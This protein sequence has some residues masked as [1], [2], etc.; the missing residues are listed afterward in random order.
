VTGKRALVLDDEPAVR[1][2]VAT[3]LTGHGYEVDAVDTV[4]AGE[5]RLGVARPDVVLLD[6][7]ALDLL[8]RLHELDPDLPAIVLTERTSVE[9][10][11]RAV[12][13]HPAPLVA[14]PIEPTV[15][16]ALVERVV[17]AGRLRR[18]EDAA[19]LH[20][21]PSTDPFIGTS[22][23]IR[24]L[25]D[26]AQRAAR[27][28][29]P[30]LI[31]GEAGTGKDALARWVHANGLRGREAV[32]AL[33]CRGL[34]GEPLQRALFGRETTASGVE[35]GLFELAHHGTLLLSNVGDVD[36]AT[37]PRL[38]AALE[39]GHVRRVDGTREILV[40]VRLAGTSRAN[41]A[42][43][44]SAARFEQEFRD[45]L[46][47]LA[48][49]VPSL[50]E[51]RE[52]IA[53]VARAVLDAVAHECG[54]PGISL[55]PDAAA[56]LEAYPWPGNVR[57]LHSVLVRAVLLADDGTIAAPH[58][59]LGTEAAGASGDVS[60]TLREV[61]RRH[62]ARVL[63]DVGG[64][65]PRAAERLGIPRSTLYQRLKKLGLAPPRPHDA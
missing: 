13:E 34:S 31:F 37:R 39:S 30:I 38:L 12:R 3:A 55:A 33:D 43:E 14:K 27:S 28:D 8:P 50:R 32:V 11:I 51:R 54:R 29:Q 6:D 4:A 17:D 21:L 47:A 62:I 52:D 25:A 56:A 65:V 40:D 36:P 53:P 58:L 64:H 63:A 61:D 19:T 26:D 2:A 45:R 42:A 15:L 46:H 24:R 59:H 22:A 49:R 44:G 7:S 20:V 60:L 16:L 10:A 1:S 48:I 35:R 57:E 23:A 41:P 18:L 9:R 5:A